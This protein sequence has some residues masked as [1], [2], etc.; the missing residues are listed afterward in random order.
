MDRRLR[1]AVA[2]LLT[3]FALLL[4]ADATPVFGSA[5]TFGAATGFAG[6]SAEGSIAKSPG[7]AAE[8][9][10]PHP[11]EECQ[12]TFKPVV[13]LDEVETTTGEEAESA[14]MEM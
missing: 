14:L 3:V 9:S 6:F 2:L 12:A 13:E 10:A 11:E 1:L 7:A 4:Q 5:S 8:D